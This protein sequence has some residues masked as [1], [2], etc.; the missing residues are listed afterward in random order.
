MGRAATLPPKLYL[1]EHHMP[2]RQ[3]GWQQKKKNKTE[4][5]PTKP[6][7]AE[8]VR[9]SSDAPPE[10]QPQ[11]TQLR[12]AATVTARIQTLDSSSEALGTKT[13]R[14][15][16][17]VR[18]QR[19]HTDLW[20]SVYYDSKPLPPLPPEAEVGASSGENSLPEQPSNSVT[21]R[22]SKRSKLNAMIEGMKGMVGKCKAEYTRHTRDARLSMAW[23]VEEFT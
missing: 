22:Q 3:A 17:T 23:E 20:T 13:L 5:D 1:F 14:R 18:R 6:T 10:A 2:S 12:R 19:A 8:R 16:S 9:T 11:Q 7:F 15:S 4:H 21:L